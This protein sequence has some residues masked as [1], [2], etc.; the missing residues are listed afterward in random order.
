MTNIRKSNRLS[1]RK[2]KSYIDFKNST[3]SEDFKLEK[4]D[5]E[6]YSSSSNDISNKNKKFK[7]SDPFFDNLGDDY[8]L[9]EDS[10]KFQIGD[11]LIFVKKLAK[12]HKD[13]N[14]QF[15]GYLDNLGNI[16]E[17]F[18]KEI[19]YEKSL[20]GNNQRY[21]N[22]E[23]EKHPFL[24]INLLYDKNFAFLIPCFIAK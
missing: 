3:D 14:R 6:A 4:F 17:C 7:K 8:V 23:F 22:F 5:T 1:T 12:N 18:V 24:S 10:E 2:K 21:I 16:E 15:F 11:K 19:Y 9:R 20:T 13:I